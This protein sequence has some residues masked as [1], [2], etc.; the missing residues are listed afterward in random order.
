M[1]DAGGSG[2][3]LLAARMEEWAPPTPLALLWTVWHDEDARHDSISFDD[4]VGRFWGGGV[5]KE[6][7]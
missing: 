4:E 1:P 2:K 3:K 6:K 5:I 7:V